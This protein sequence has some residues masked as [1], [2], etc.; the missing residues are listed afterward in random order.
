MFFR[1]NEIGDLL[2]YYEKNYRDYKLFYCERGEPIVQSSILFLYKI[3][4]FF[5]EKKINK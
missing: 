2:D 5:L 4:E 1:E 3:H